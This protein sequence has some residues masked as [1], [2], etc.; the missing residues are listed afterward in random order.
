MTH[1]ELTY[2]NYFNLRE[3]GFDGIIHDF[4]TL[5]ALYYIINDNEKFKFLINKIKQGYSITF[6]FASE[7]IIDRVGTIN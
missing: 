5:K 7:H 1:Y 6:V 3:N 2:D 4:A